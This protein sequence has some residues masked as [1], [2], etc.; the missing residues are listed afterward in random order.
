MK[1][2]VKNLFV[3]TAIVA[4]FASC[5]AQ[6]GSSADVQPTK[7]QLLQQFLNPQEKSDYVPA[8]FFLH[9]ADKLGDK[10]AQSH[11]KYFRA[12]NMDF[13]KIQYE[14]VVPVT[15]KEPADL[16]KVPVYDQEY[17][18]P[19]V[20]TI[21]QIAD[22]LR[23]EAFILPTV[24]SPL[25]L[26]HQSVGRG[27]SHEEFLK[28]LTADPALTEQAFANI[29]KSIENYIAAARQAGAD[30]F[31][32]SSQG[33]DNKSLAGTTLWKDFV[34]KYD[35]K[36][37]EYAYSVSDL[38]ILHVCD[39]GSSYSELDSYADYPSTI[40]NPPIHLEGGE[41][42]LRHIAEVFKRPVFGGLD[43]LGSIAKGSIADAKAEVDRVLQ[44]APEQFILG[45][46]C[47]VPSDTDY[48]K[49]RAIIDYAHSWRRTHGTN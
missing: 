39:Y 30:G 14:Q 29:E 48:G 24:Y 28:L 6:A 44:N 11:I 41:V 8:A 16:A 15:V 45:A 18:K 42:D 26:I 19:Q 13:V 7:R 34:R 25:A 10:A 2:L 38:T 5:N 9:F 43:R 40:I 27:V 12:T 3:A 23:G 20:E 1:S 47:T 33:G 32:V 22:S 37:S 36:V 4:T 21:R 46:D 31:Y 35:K 49:L 17:W